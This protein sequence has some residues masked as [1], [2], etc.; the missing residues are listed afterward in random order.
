MDFHSAETKLPFQLPFRASILSLSYQNTSLEFSLSIGAKICT[1]CP[2]KSSLQRGSTSFQEQT[3]LKVQ[4]K[5]QF[6]LK[7]LEVSTVKFALCFQCS[8]CKSTHFNSNIPI[9]F[10]CWK[11]RNYKTLD[12]AA[13]LH[14]CVED[15]RC[16]LMLFEELHC[17]FYWEK[18]FPYRLST[19]WLGQ[20]WNYRLLA[21][22]DNLQWPFSFEYRA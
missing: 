1:L 15:H 3:P 2:Y 12:L 20:W 8:G 9:C 14:K 4:V 10:S 18:H 6:D 19:I 16:L 11:R 5:L 21:S 7:S 17:L 22:F 13:L